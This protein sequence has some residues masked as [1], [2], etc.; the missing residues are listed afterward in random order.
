M[1]SRDIRKWLCFLVALAI[2]LSAVPAFASETGSVSDKE[3]L[4]KVE[5]ADGVE[6]GDFT[7]GIG[8]YDPENAGPIDVT[9][10]LSAF[11][12]REIVSGASVDSSADTATVVLSSLPED[13]VDALAGD[14]LAKVAF[15]FVD[16]N[17]DP[18]QVESEGG[19]ITTAQPITRGFKRGEAK[20][21]GDVVKGLPEGFS[22]LNAEEPIDTSAEFNN[23]EVVLA[24]PITEAG[25]PRTMAVGPDG[26]FTEVL[27]ESVADVNL[28]AI[29]M[30]PKQIVKISDSKDV[31][32]KQEDEIIFD[33]YNAEEIDVLLASFTPE[34][35]AEIE[36]SE[37]VTVS[38]IMN[39]YF[40]MF[41]ND[42]EIIVKDIDVFVP[43]KKVATT[44]PKTADP[45]SMM[46][47]VTLMVSG[48][49]MV[50]L[51]KKIK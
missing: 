23:Q 47:L 36:N 1:K 31:T 8:N 50:A 22:L 24:A 49:G 7:I 37:N 9:G 20:V 45:T 5:N 44:I 46:S 10:K 48:L 28:M 21:V 27:L 11:G 30:A 18:I 29:E 38:Q 35:R 26:N 6:L 4:V 14:A 2:V 40:N 13:S 17:G 51:K 12:E 43:I 33:V 32:I 19:I 25:T 39:I 3:I 16:Q 15:Y 42:P 41:L 34:Q